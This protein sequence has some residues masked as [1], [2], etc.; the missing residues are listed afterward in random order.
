MQHA[1]GSAVP[2]KQLDDDLA[3]KKSPKA[4]LAAAKRAHEQAKYGALGEGWQ[5]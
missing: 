4:E 3:T 5:Q 2:Q 1:I